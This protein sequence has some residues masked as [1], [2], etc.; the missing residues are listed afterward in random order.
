MNTALY[1]AYVAAERFVLVAT[2]AGS[3]FEFPSPLTRFPGCLPLMVDALAVPLVTRALCFTPQHRW[4]GASPDGFRPRLLGTVSRGDGTSTLTQPC[5]GVYDPEFPMPAFNSEYSWNMNKGS[6]WVK[7]DLGAR[8]WLLNEEADIYNL[9][10][11][12]KNFLHSMLPAAAMGYIAR[13]FPV[14]PLACLYRQLLDVLKPSSSAP[15]RY[16]QQPL[17]DVR[18]LHYQRLIAGVVVHSM[19]TLDEVRALQRADSDILEVI[20]YHEQ[21]RRV[22]DRPRGALHRD[23]PFTHLEHGVLYYRASFGDDDNFCHGVV[24][25]KPLIPRVLKALHDSATYGH[26]GVRA[27]IQIVRQHVYW[28]G[29][30]KAIREYIA[31]CD[32]CKRAK[33]EVKSHAGHQISDFYYMPWQRM[34]VDCLGPFPGGES[35]LHFICWATGFNYIVIIPNKKAATVAAATFQF[36]QLFG[37]PQEIISDNGKEFL[38]ALMAALLANHNVK[39]VKSTPMN[40]K[41]NSRTER[42]HRDYNRILRIC[43]QKYGVS[44]K[45][46]AFIAN[47]CLNVTPRS[48]TPVS[49][50]ECLLGFKPNM[51][52]ESLMSEYSGMTFKQ[53]FKKTN[54]SDEQIGLQL[55]MHRAWCMNLVE[56]VIQEQTMRNKQASDDI[57]YEVT[58]NVGDLVLLARPV[59]G[60]RKRGTTTR[61]LFQNIGPFEVMEYIGNNAYRLRKLGTDTVTTH[62][63]KYMNP[64]LTKSAYEKQTLPLVDPDAPQ[65]V[66][67]P[68]SPMPGDFMLFTGLSGSDVLY[69]LVTIL[70]YHTDS[71]EVEFTYLNNSTTTGHLRNFRPVWTAIDQVEK[72]QMRA[73]KGNYSRAPHSAHRDHFCWTS[74]PVQKT[75]NG[76]NLTAL[77]VRKAMEMRVRSPVLSVPAKSE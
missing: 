64:Y 10:D 19:P 56:Q 75:S 12:A 15:L 45:L 30:V 18:M 28:R 42:R 70:E 17:D 38:N 43:V 51:P 21:G 22:S 53:V 23:A 74:I 24:L 61:L 57:T 62:N 77:N 59:I 1:G 48:G 27:T 8:Q 67:P 52:A 44:W 20:L 41:G 9:D 76:F 47:W 7:D 69:H 72:Q 49:A 32:T 29:M 33:T 60:S 46:G 66:I 50:Y 35:I 65:V 73:P 71:E 4:F 11:T 58:Y 37:E 63:V 6:Q 26:P 40:P 14:A 2:P 16:D 31:N 36:F 5:T 68:Y 34:G 55:D 3:G 25:P 54:L 39:H 13:C